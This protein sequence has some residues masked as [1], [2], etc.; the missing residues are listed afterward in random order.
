MSLVALIEFTERSKK[1][2]CG[3]VSLQVE[4][5]SMDWMFP[6]VRDT[7]KA[8]QK[9]QIWF[10]LQE[11]KIINY[12]I[13]HPKLYCLTAGKVYFPNHNETKSQNIKTNH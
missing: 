7:S 12:K 1:K 9:S 11:K 5:T 6:V 13:L 4:K 3:S 2:F 8:G 10:F